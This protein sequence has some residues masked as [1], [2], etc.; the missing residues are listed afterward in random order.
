MPSQCGLH[1]RET[2][3]QLHAEPFPVF[4]HIC[5]SLVFGT[6]CTASSSADITY[7][8]SAIMYCT[9]AITYCTAASFWL[10]F[11]LQLALEVKTTS[12]DFWCHN[13]VLIIVF[14][15]LLIWYQ[16][17]TWCRS[18]LNGLCFLCRPVGALTFADLS[19]NNWCALMQKHT[20]QSQFSSTWHAVY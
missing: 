1:I 13:V 18:T 15:Q 17:F 11:M 19:I 4:F 12:A 10:M 2:T 9:S 8:T 14:C 16:G 6:V 5:Q 3:R 7:C 20:S